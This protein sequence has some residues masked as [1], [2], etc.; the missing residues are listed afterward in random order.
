MNSRSQGFLKLSSDRQADRQTESTEI[1]KH[2]TLQVVNKVL[3]FNFKHITCI[4]AMGLN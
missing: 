3:Q 4:S 2:A 1:I